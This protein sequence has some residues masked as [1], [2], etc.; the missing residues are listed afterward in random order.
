MDTPPRYEDAISATNQLLSEASSSLTPPISEVK[1]PTLIADKIAAVCRKYEISPFFA[2]KLWKLQGCEILPMI[3]DS[4]SMNTRIKMDDGSYKTRYQYAEELV[5][6]FAD[7][8]TLFNDDGF[9]VHFLH[10]PPML[11]M[12]SASDL[13]QCFSK[14]PEGNTPMGYALRRVFKESKTALAKDK[15]LL[16]I[17]IT[18]GEPSDEADFRRAMDYDRFSMAK[19]GQISITFA[20]CTD[21]ESVIESYNKID[22][23][24]E[25]VDVVSDYAKEKKQVLQVLKSRG[26]QY[27]TF[28]RGDYIC[29][30]LLGSIDAEVDAID[31]MPK[32][33]SGCVIS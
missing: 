3:D 20:L 2:E 1:K 17:A 22:E 23:D 6:M 18:D 12:K 14:T 32:K 15:K 33:R 11:R 16:I 25:F 31:E 4:G 8:T 21:E 5:Q 30:L 19:R 29:K 27:P 13:K 9:N 24:C 10:G 7:F 26:V 28:T